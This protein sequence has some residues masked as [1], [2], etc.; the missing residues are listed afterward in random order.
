MQDLFKAFWGSE[1]KVEIKLTS[2]Y[3]VGVQKKY[4][5]RN[6]RGVLIKCPD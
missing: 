6:S 3:R 2:A 5:Q 4:H 1:S